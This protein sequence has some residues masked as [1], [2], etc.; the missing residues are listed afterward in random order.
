MNEVAQ[1]EL[2]VL[3][4]A[5]LLESWQ[6]HRRLTRRTI[7][8]FPED[9]LFS[10]SVGGM[11][12]FGAIAWELHNVAAYTLGGMVSGEWT[13]PQWSEKPPQDRASLLA[14]WDDLTARLDALLPTVPPAR[15]HEVQKTFWATMPGHA[16][17]LYALD[18]EIHHRGQ[19]YVYLR[20][21]GVEPVPFWER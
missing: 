8:Q 6:G 4:P 9:Q 16:I 3:T 7:E 20:A 5:D 19:G 11:R 12:P 2:P 14:A 10:F 1:K 21:L 13:E 17:T 18:N 15:Y